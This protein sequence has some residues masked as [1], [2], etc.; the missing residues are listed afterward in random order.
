MNATQ[1][2]IGEIV[3]AELVKAAIKS[4]ENAMM[5]CG[6]NSRCVSVSSIPSGDSR[7]ITGMIG[8]HGRVTGFATVNMSEQVALKTVG[9]LLQEQHDKLCTQVVDGAGELTNIIVGGI[10]SQL[11]GSRWAFNYM[12]TPSVIIGGGYQIAFGNGLDFMA[13]TFEIEDKE[14]IMIEERLLTISLSLLTI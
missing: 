13:A 14:S 7:L 3:H 4:V 10:K 11:A 6:C 9:G 12:T 5:M 1:D 8:L 2:F